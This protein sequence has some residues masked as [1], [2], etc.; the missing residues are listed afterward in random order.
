MW[1]HDGEQ[2]D[3]TLRKPS[4]RNANFQNAQIWS[5]LLPLQKDSMKGSFK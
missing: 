2:V 1:H 3:S 4:M 5:Q